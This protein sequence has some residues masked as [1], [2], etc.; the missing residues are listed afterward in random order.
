ML[1][2]LAG[3]A[4]AL[5]LAKA[6]SM[7]DFFARCL[8]IGAAGSV[9][10]ILRYLVAISVGRF[11]LRFPLGTLIINITGSIFLGWFSSYILRHN[12][13]DVTRLAIGVG[14][15]GAYTTFSTFMF[16]TNKLADDGA[17]FQAMANILISLALGLIGVRL[18]IYLGKMG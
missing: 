10:A 2:A 8:A 3:H 14:F 17:M 4:R 5:S 15:V 11:D 16:E 13:S 9:G 1:F 12:V 6:L 18:G 7:N